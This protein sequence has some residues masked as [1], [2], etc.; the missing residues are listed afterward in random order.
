[1]Y[2]RINLIAALMVIT[3][4][5]SWAQE[6]QVPVDHSH[7]SVAAVRKQSDEVRE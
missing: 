4:S 2:R 6:D 1:M 5:S 3:M 7:H